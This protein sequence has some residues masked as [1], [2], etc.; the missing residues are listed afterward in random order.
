[1]SCLIA[2]LVVPDELAAERF[3]AG[4]LPYLSELNVNLASDSQGQAMK[5]L[6][7]EY[8]KAVPP[9]E[10]HAEMGLIYESRPWPVS[11]YD[12]SESVTAWG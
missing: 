6:M 10:E 5:D 3:A 2:V 8:G 9:S 12:T 11:Y 7:A 4:D 1:M